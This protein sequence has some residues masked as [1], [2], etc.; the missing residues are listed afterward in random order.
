VLQKAERAEIG[1]E[2]ESLPPRHTAAN[3]KAGRAIKSSRLFVGRSLLHP[4]LQ[5]ERPKQK[6]RYNSLCPPTVPFFAVP[7]VLIV[8]GRHTEKKPGMNPAFALA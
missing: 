5:W 3:T 8:A 7:P 6:R 1:A 2:P 4:T